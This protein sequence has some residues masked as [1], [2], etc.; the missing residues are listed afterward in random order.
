MKKL[1]KTDI[2]KITQLQF[3]NIT[4]KEYIFNITEILYL[5]EFIQKINW[6]KE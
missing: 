6:K 1:E 2:F 5:D 3:P 4:N